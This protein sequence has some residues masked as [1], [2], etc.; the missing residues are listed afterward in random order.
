MKQITGGGWGGGYKHCA[1]LTIQSSY[2]ISDFLW[3]NG[4]TFVSTISNKRTSN[5][6]IF[7]G[8]MHVK[9]FQKKSVSVK[10]LDLNLS[11]VIFL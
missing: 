3:E 11:S 1:L 2:L 9:K 8:E 7:V 6:I 5:K 4:N 10:A